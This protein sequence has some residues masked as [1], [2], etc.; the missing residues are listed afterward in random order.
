[1]PKFAVQALT[2]A[3]AKELASDGFTV[4]AYCPGIVSTAM[5]VEIDRRFTE[6][7]GADVGAT[8]VEYVEGIALG[9]HRHPRT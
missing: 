6:L 7:T 8:Y 4:N 9:G 2:Q 5:W 1:M 3:A